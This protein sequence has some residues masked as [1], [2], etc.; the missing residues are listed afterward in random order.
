MVNYL[1]NTHPSKEMSVAEVTKYIIEG[2]LA[3][4]YKRQQDAIDILIDKNNNLNSSSNNAFYYFD[5][6]Y[7][8]TSMLRNRYDIT[9]VIHL[10]LERQMSFC[11]TDEDETECD[12]QELIQLCGLCLQGVKDIIDI[13]NFFPIEVMRVAPNFLQDLKRTKPK[14]FMRNPTDKKLKYFDRILEIIRKYEV[15]NLV[16]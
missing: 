11:K 5:K 6:L 14:G 9:P 12:K 8:H 13:V 15:N 2:F 10:D 1:G 3:K 4:Q 7:I 16:G